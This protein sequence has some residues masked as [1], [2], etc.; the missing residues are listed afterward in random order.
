MSMWTKPGSY[1]WK[2]FFE[3]GAMPS[4]STK[5][6]RSDTPCRRK[7]RPKPARETAGLMN[8]RVTAS[9]SSVGSSSV[10]RSYC[11]D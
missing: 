2:V 7:Q 11:H 5:S 9:R 6:R 1:F 10:V 4:C 8:S 3:A